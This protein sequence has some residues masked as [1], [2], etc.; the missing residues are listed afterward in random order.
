MLL[1]GQPFSGV[2]TYIGGSTSNGADSYA[3]ST[4]RRGGRLPQGLYE[5]RVIL[6]G[7]TLVSSYVNW[8]C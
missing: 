8:S 7:K 4:R 1:D 6:G 3:V 2:N 5:V